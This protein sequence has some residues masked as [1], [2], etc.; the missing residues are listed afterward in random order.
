MIPVKKP[1]RRE[2]LEK[3][4]HNA[5]GY[6]EIREIRNKIVERRDFHKSIDEIADKDYSTNTYFGVCPRKEKGGGAD[7]VGCV[8]ALWSD[9]DCGPGKD[10]PSQSEAM[11]RVSSF[12]YEPSIVVS[13]G[14]GIHPYWLLREPVAPDTVTE[15]ILKGV[16]KHLGADMACAEFARVMR[17]PDTVNDKSSP[18]KKCEVLKLTDLRYNLSDFDGYAEKIDTVKTYSDPADNGG[19]TVKDVL[20]KWDAFSGVETPMRKISKELAGSHPM[21]GS[22]TG[23]NFNLNPE[24]NA[25][26]CRRHN[27]GGGPLQLISVLEGIIDCSEAKPGGLRGE[28]F[29]ETCRVAKEKYGF[30]VKR[31]AETILS[32]DEITTLE[33]RIK[34][35]PKDTAR[36]RIPGL[37][38]PILKEIAKIDVPQGD[39]FLKDTVKKHFSFTLNDLKSYETQLAEYRNE[40]AGRN[41]PHQGEALTRICEESIKTY[42]TDQQGEPFIVLPINNH[43]ETCSARS[44]RLRNWLAGLFREKN[45][46]PPTSDALKQAQIQVEVRCSKTDQIELFNRIGWCEGAIYYDLTAPDWSGVKIT[47]EGWEIA[48]LPPVFR[49]YKHQARQVTPTKDESPNN[50]LKFCNIRE[51]DHCLFMVTLATFFIPDFPHAIPN[52]DGA[53]GSGKSVTSKN[54][55]NLIDPSVVTL[56]STPK[57][58]EHVQMT[59]EK[60]WVSTFDNISRVPEWFSD[61]LCRG[62][63]G[64]GDMK[65]SLYTNDDEFIRSYRRCF[66]LNGIGTYAERPDLL[67]RSIIF[68]IPELGVKRPEDDIKEEW[69]QMLPGILG[70]FF[71]AISKAMGV[72]D[73]IKGHEAF[74]MSDFARWGA[75]LAGPLGYSQDE[76]FTKYQESVKRKWEEAADINT[77]SGKIVELV[78]SQGKWKGSYSDLLEAINPKN[79]NRDKNLPDS[80]RKLSSALKRIGPLLHTRKIKVAYPDKREAGIGR[81]LIVLH[82]ADEQIKGVNVGVNVCECPVNVD[83]TFDPDLFKN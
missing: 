25:W 51:D 30:D 24:K 44:T 82:W 49:R 68:E 67:D 74:R 78:Q 46:H 2:F 26:T 66:V 65:R 29:L 31:Q 15:G 72:V 52:L 59:A 7:S 45:Q 6:I 70:G 41:N 1:S 63:T 42:F 12:E 37:L 60:H 80:P 9:L 56:M 53:Q 36:V 64:E 5:D 47:K 35:I 62:V 16:S 71:T 50:L 79:P 43:L 28:K 69:R 11:K 10:F 8:M 40:P 54:I 73:Q 38:N 83:D 76:F 13:S 77:L 14:N 58:L 33:T 4:F 55:K 3:I 18:V 19:L 23:G 57:D 61:F 27:T 48:A 39:F 20:R 17:L 32:D 75:A 81:H 21:H 22:T 34:A